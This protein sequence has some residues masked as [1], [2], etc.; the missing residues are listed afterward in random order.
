MNC[1]RIYL[2]GPSQCPHLDYLPEV[3][4]SSGRPWYNG[5]RLA[6]PVQSTDLLL[7]LLG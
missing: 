1:Q 4:L 5:S 2:I 6:P 7:L 3:L